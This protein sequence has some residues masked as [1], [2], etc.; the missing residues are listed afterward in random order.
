MG[1]GEVALKGLW[2]ALVK[3][4]GEAIVDG[5][6]G[7]IADIAPAVEIAVRNFF[8][9]ITAYIYDFITVL[10]KLFQFVSQVDII[11]G[12]D[13]SIVNNIYKKITMILGI[14]MIFK[15][16]FTLIQSL[17][18]PDK[19]T[20]KRN[21]FTSIIVRLI[22]SIVLLGM[23]PTIFKEARNLQKILTGVDDPNDNI[24]YKLIVGNPEELNKEDDIGWEL[25]SDVF[26][27][28][29][30]DNQAPK[31][32]D[33][34]FPAGS[35]S[36][37]YDIDVKFQ[38]EC[39]PGQQ[40]D[41]T[42]ENSTKCLKP[43]GY[44]RTFLDAVPFLELTDTDDKSVTKGVYIIEFNW[45][46]AVIFGI[47]FAWLLILYTVQTGIRVVQLAYLQII[48]PIPIFMYISEPD[49]SFKKWWK[50]CI[51]TYLDLFIRMAIIYFV[52]YIVKLLIN[53]FENIP[54]ADANNVF[55]VDGL[56]KDSPYLIWIKI[57]LFLSLFLFAKRVPDLLKDLFPG[58]GAGAAG[59]DFG[60]LTPKKAF[61]KYLAGAPI[62]G[63]PI[64]WFGNK[65]SGGVKK[66]VAGVKKG[67][68]GTAKAIAGIPKKT[69][70]A[71]DRK[72]HGIPKPR[73]KFLQAIDK[74]APGFAEASK[75]KQQAKLETAKH[76][77]KMSF[78]E[79]YSK[80]NLSETFSGEYKKSYD[81]LN[82]AKSDVKI[83]KGKLETAQ[84][85]YEIALRSN[86]ENAIKN[87]KIALNKA[88][89]NVQDVEGKFNVAQ[90]AH[91]INKKNVK[92][93]KFAEIEDAVGYYKSHT[94]VSDSASSSEISNYESIKNNPVGKD[95]VP[96]TDKS[97]DSTV[98]DN[99]KTKYP[100]NSNGVD[101]EELYSSG[102]QDEMDERINMIA[103]KIYNGGAQIA[104]ID[105]Y[106]EILK[107]LVNNKKLFDLTEKG[108][109]EEEINKYLESI[110]DLV[111]NEKS[112]DELKQ[113]IDDQLD[114]FY[115]R[116]DD[117][118]G[119]Q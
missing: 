118:Y 28:F 111:D 92:Y 38:I 26:F 79:A 39:K 46:F 2:D 45:L 68:K 88:Q 66:G 81:N 72:V 83:A 57:V 59:L 31:F 40:Y 48:A 80:K 71:I 22:T 51:A 9:T 75:N 108:A 6:Q 65:V 50:Q 85:N 41:P 82:I 114:D 119:G 112:L 86:D 19:F 90:E 44:N 14:F 27:S 97:A 98:E 8:A 42:R 4:A 62:I 16:S 84:N 58:L 74:M 23:T 56:T 93:A 25:A 94:Y 35:E 13:G 107:D 53:Y 52:I 105:R 89:K 11:N 103:E 54:A 34:P 24:L 77:K 64:G 87:A 17:V 36:K 73:N 7:I 12:A 37:K 29:Y 69:I 47:I 109:S 60:L 100:T 1:W 95:D 76:E 33:L 61:D 55:G 78:G 32:D 110:E 99:N 3:P 49:G 113:E 101:L 116:Q 30:Q 67:V 5:V 70:T 15:L 115:D 96:K 102:S 104:E 63:K 10:Y 20:D 18:D 91:N 106:E 21:G 43:V 117:G